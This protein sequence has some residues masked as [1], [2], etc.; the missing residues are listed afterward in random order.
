MGIT[1]LFRGRS[2]QPKRIVYRGG[3]ATFDVPAHW[4]D[5]YESEGGATFYDDRPDSG[6]LRLNVLSFSSEKPASQMVLSAF[7]GEDPPRSDGFP[8]R[9]LVESAAE[10]GEP[11]EIHRWEIAIPVEPN[12]M[13]L[14]LF[15]YTIVQGQQADPRIREELS[16][17]DALIRSAVFSTDAGVPAA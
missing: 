16:I 8:M 10:N 3:I 14:A 7:Q 13:R 15:S 4:L 17:V 11:L 5:E 12:R 1:S 2:K 6:T 9:Y